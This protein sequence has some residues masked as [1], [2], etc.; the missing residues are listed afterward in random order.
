VLRAALVRPRVRLS[1][2]GNGHEKA[3]G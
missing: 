3:G 1:L 2:L